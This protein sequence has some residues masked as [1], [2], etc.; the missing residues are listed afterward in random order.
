[1]PPPALLDHRI[2]NA[3]DSRECQGDGTNQQ[4]VHPLIIPGANNLTP[5]PRSNSPDPAHGVHKD[6]NLQTGLLQ[7]LLLNNPAVGMRKIPLTSSL[8]H[9]LLQVPLN[10]PAA[11][12]R[13]IPL[14]SSL[15]HGVH[16]APLSNSRQPGV[17]QLRHNNPAAGAIKVQ[18]LRADSSHGMPPHRR[19][20]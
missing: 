14:T 12:M 5:G 19:H 17:L 3:R 18:G 6:S 15:L 8:L 20:L 9:G 13:K 1:M 2:G 4:R 7:T 10:N 11:G 16:K